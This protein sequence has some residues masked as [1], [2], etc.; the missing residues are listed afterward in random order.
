MALHFEKPESPSRKWYR[1]NKERLSALRKKKY[2]ED[3]QYRE[4]IK[5]GVKRRRETGRVKSIPAGSLC[6]KQAA[7]QADITVARLRHWEEE[8]YFPE[9]RSEYGYC[10]FTCHQVLLLQELKQ[11]FYKYGKRAWRT[12]HKAA[13]REL[14]ASIKARW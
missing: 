9:P 3:S 11:F 12:Y 8:H 5:A 6:A 2:V 10:L 4:Q 1:Q 7:D 14:V 13:L